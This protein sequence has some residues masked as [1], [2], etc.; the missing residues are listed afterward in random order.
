MGGIWYTLDDNSPSPYG[1]L[2]GIYEDAEGNDYN[3]SSLAQEGL[4][5]KTYQSDLFNNWLDTEF[6]DGTNGVGEVTRVNT[7]TGSFTIDELNLKSKVYVMLN[8]IAM[9]GGTYDDWLMSVYDAERVNSIQNPVYEGGLIKELVF[10]E[11]IS[12][13]ASE[14]QP[15]GTLAGRGRMGGKHKGGQ[16]TVKVK[17]PSYIMGI[18]SITPRIDYSQGNKW[19][20]NLLTFNDFHKPQLDEIGFQDLITDQM[21]YFDTKLDSGGS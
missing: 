8:R 19:D 1:D 12:N 6:I 5:I 20:M 9:S 7:A 15:L 11:V 16:V 18:V 13:A 3:Y 14:E 2:L 17:E 21:A 10:Q 4:G